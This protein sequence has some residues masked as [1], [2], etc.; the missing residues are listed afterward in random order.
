VQESAILAE[1]LLRGPQTPGEL[2][3]RCTRMYPFP[4]LQEVESALQLLLEST[5]PLVHRLQRQPGTKEARFSHLLG[6]AGPAPTAA[7]PQEHATGLASEVAL[8][9]EELAQL[10]AA[11]EAFRKQFE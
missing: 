1:L 4:D 8:L 5:P 2:R 10:R 9:R 3:S 6:E 7:P 11:F